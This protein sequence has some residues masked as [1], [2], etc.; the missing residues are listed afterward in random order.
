[1]FPFILCFYHRENLELGCSPGRGNMADKEWKVDTGH[2][3]QMRKEEK[4]QG[5]KTVVAIADFFARDETQLS[6]S[7]GDELVILSEE[8]TDWWWGE[9]D[10]TRGYV[11][12]S[13]VAT[14]ADYA[15]HYTN[16][17]DWQ[18]EE[19][20][21][22]YGKLKLHL[23][24]LGDQPRTL[25]YRKAINRHRDVFIGKTVLDVG[26]GTGILSLFCAKDGQA[27]KVFAVDGSVDIGSV[28]T[29]IVKI[30]DSN[31]II[32]VFI[33]K[34]EDIELPEKVDIILSEWMGTFLVFEFMI[35]SVLCARD[36]WLKSDGI[37]WPS[38]AKLFIVPCSAKKAYDEKVTVWSNQY[39]FD[40]SPILGRVKTEFLDRPLHNY[41]LD[42]EDCLSQSA[43]VLDIDMKTFSRENLELMTEQ[44]EFVI[45]KKGTFHGLCAWFSVIFGGVPV[46]DISDYE[47]LS[48]GPDHERTHWK[49]NLFLLDEPILVNTGN[50][51][52]GS[53]TLKRNPKYRRHLSVTFDFKVF[54]M[55]SNGTVVH[56][57]K[58]KFFI[59]R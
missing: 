39:G 57:I 7:E 43:V 24:M 41:E 45:R 29:E 58:K 34:I 55:K 35:D 56:N 37:I 27:K 5:A 36:K 23:E 3:Y 38:N 12:V 48:T 42:Q 59:W 54:S 25:A 33:G 8:S 20:F 4:K 26:C 14:E 17:H 6:F 50:F 28:T 51:I 11:P 2:N 44:F 53:A 16:H 13:Y 30:N 22:D 47:M 19:Y 10:G 18:D 46:T 32:S 21:G 9:L 52:S 31:N 15:R 40:F 1:M 49:Q